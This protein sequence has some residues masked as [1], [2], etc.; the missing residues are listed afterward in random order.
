MAERYDEMNLNYRRTSTQERGWSSETMDEFNRLDGNEIWFDMDKD[1]TT[2]G[3]MFYEKWRKVNTESMTLW[4]DSME[5]MTTLR[6]FGKLF[7][8]EIRL[9]EG[10]SPPTLGRDFFD[11]YGWMLMDNG[12]IKSPSGN[13]ITTS[14]SASGT[15]GMIQQS[16]TEGVFKCTELALQSDT[17]GERKKVLFKLHKYFGHVS[18]E[19][20]YRILKASSASEK[21]TES[22]IRMIND[23]CLICRT[24]KR[25]MNKKK[26][27][28]PRSSGF[29]Q[30]VTL[31][32][33]VHSMTEYVLWCVDDATRMIRGEVVKDKKPETILNALERA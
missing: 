31:D 14:V 13:I 25:K 28:L 32:L 19:S 11:R 26:T 12:M 33:K 18:P 27:S 30:V 5:L 6:M 23:K 8:C 20:L 22:E 17:P 10:T 9:I 3:Q 1:I 15:C 29:N 4:R 21:F 24:T 7:V 16:E 2:M